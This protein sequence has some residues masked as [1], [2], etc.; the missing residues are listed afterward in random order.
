MLLSDLD[1]VVGISAATTTALGMSATAPAATISSTRLTTGLTTGSQQE[2]LSHT[3]GI[4][5]EDPNCDRSL[6]TIGAVISLVTLGATSAV[7]PNASG[8]KIDINNQPVATGTGAA[9]ATSAGCNTKPTIGNL[10]GMATLAVAL[11][12]FVLV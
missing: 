6:T 4:S 8:E 10:L 5:N 3:S 7:E 11:V 9:T 12:I 2:I 1:L